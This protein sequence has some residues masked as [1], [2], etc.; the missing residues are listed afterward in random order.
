MK[1]QKLTPDTPIFKNQ[2][3][4]MNWVK[5]RQKGKG[6]FVHMNYDCGDME[7]N[8]SIFN[9][10]NSNSTNISSDSGN[11]DSSSTIDSVST[12]IGE[13]LQLIS[14]K[15]KHKSKNDQ[16]INLKK[17]L[18]W[19]KLPSSRMPAK[20]FYDSSSKQIRFYFDILFEELQLNQLLNIKDASKLL[21]SEER[22]FELRVKDG[23]HWARITFTRVDDGTLLLL[24]FNKS[25]NKT[26]PIEIKK[27]INYKKDYLKRR[28]GEEV[29]L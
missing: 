15:N 25:Q 10:S 7:H 4:L 23:N 28:D 29:I 16:S 18:I 9:N 26:D 24:G 14:E 5:K 12:G 17:K 3:Q 20:E 6:S 13:S 11:V 21:N 27:S 8:N 1:I 22:I 19:Y 2:K